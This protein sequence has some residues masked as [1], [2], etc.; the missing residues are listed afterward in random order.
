MILRCGLL[1]TAYVEIPKL[2]PQVH[3]VKPSAGHGVSGAPLGGDGTQT[4]RIDSMEE[5]K[6]GNRASHSPRPV[7]NK[8]PSGPVKDF[9]VSFPSL[10]PQRGSFAGL[11]PHV[12]GYIALS[13]WMPPGHF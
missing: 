7:V 11:K 5:M 1:I 13:F 3:P 9:S 6:R 2:R 12:L 4:S 8:D 10:P